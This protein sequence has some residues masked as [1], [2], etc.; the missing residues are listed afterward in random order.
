ME[1]NCKKDVKRRVG[2]LLVESELLHYNCANLK[3]NIKTPHTL[4]TLTKLQLGFITKGI[5]INGCYVKM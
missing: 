3:Y 1:R 5:T 4:H 2:D